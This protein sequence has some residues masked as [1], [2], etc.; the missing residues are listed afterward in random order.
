ML[1]FKQCFIRFGHVS[2]LSQSAKD[3]WKHGNMETQN[4]ISHGSTWKHMASH[5]SPVAH[6]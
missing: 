5:V 2:Q 4:Q 1:I 6:A 3:A